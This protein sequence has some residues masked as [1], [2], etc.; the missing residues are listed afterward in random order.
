MVIVGLMRVLIGPC[1]IE[2]FVEIVYTKD[3][4]GVLIGPCGIETYSPTETSPEISRY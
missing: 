2:T 1:G 3:G 4:S